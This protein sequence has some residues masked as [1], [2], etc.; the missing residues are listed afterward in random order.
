[1][2]YLYKSL[3]QTTITRGLKYNNVSL[4]L[5]SAFSTRPLGQTSTLKNSLT[6]W[7]NSN[8][9][10]FGSKSTK[11]K[12]NEATKRKQVKMGEI[13]RL[14]SL[15]NPHKLRLSLAMGLLLISS[16]VS[17]SVPF[18]IGKLIDFIQ[19]GDKE[20]MKEKLR[21]VSL[22]MLGVFFVGAVANFGRIYLIQS[23]GERIIM[24]LRQDLFKSTMDQ[25][26][27]FFDRNKTGELINRLSSDA[28]L[29]GYA[30]SQNLRY[31]F[32]R[33]V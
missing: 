9:R 13:R 24:R 1:M 30:I 14:I 2:I 8:I 16:G 32:M 33:K 28:E 4:F 21:N 17:M 29:V 15:A 7:N 11:G 25:E 23:T 27:A 20:T 31:F 5:K 10:Q 3:I 26:M 12:G 18:F 22:I 19:T 6:K